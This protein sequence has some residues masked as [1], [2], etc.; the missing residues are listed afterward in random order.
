MATNNEGLLTVA[1]S[2]ERRET[3]EPG[4]YLVFS[5]QGEAYGV[6]LASVREIISYTRPTSVPMMPG[7]MLGVINL[8][9]HVVPVIDLARRFGGEATPIHKRSGVVILE[10]AGQALGVVVDAVNAVMD[11]GDGQ[12]EP[13]PSFGTGLRRRFITG[14]ARTDD[15]FTILLDVGQV[16]STD[17]LAEML[18]AAEAQST[19]EVASPMQ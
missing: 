8:R 7:F 17:E 12:I 18:D 9:G 14:M 2:P 5:L 3:G 10:T 6:E 13:T 4:Q 11:F 19:R 16:F 15:G 1:S